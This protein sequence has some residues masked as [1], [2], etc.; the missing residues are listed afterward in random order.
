ME[1]TKHWAA[2]LEDYAIDLQWSPEGAQLAAAAASGPIGVFAAADGAKGPVLPGHANGTN[3]LAWMPAEDTPARTL[4]SGGQDG[5]VK[6]WD[7][8]AGQHAAWVE[9]GSAWVEHLAWRPRGIPGAAV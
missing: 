3:C 6:L 1:L 2:T 4:A 9:L 5:E 7:A 8:P